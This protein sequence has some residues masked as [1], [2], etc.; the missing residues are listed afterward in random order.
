[1]LKL[2]KKNIKTDRLLVFIGKYELVFF[3]PKD[4]KRTY[5]KIS[6]NDIFDYADKVKDVIKNKIITLDKTEFDSIDFYFINDLFTLVPNILFKEEIAKEYL[7]T[8]FPLYNYEKVL[9]KVNKNNN[10]TLIFSC[11][12]DIQFYINA[13]ITNFNLNHIGNLTL[14]NILPK[15]EKNE[16]HIVLHEKQV[17]LLLFNQKELIDYSINENLCK[18]DLI[19]NLFTKIETHGF[20]KEKTQYYFYNSVSKEHNIFFKKYVSNLTSIKDFKY[21]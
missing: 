14:A 16:I 19:Y 18:E 2:F 1:M 11:L 6:S 10:L 3:S 7:Q 5:I 12:E 15:T 17:E 21:A 9:H 4:K 13:K 8:T 20:D